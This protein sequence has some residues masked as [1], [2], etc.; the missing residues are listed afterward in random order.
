MPY[1]K[2]SDFKEPP[3]GPKLWRFTDF[4]KFYAMMSSNSLYF[5]RLDRLEDQFEGHFS[6]ARI[7]LDQKIYDL[8]DTNDHRKNV[9]K[10][11]Y[12]PIRK[13]SFVICWHMNEYECHSTL[14]TIESNV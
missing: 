2:H 9:L 11:I 1:T 14:V 4:A 6:Q 5:S 7:E 10:M 8:P 3:E 13:D 12:A